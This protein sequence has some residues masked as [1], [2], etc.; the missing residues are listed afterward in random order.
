MRWGWI[1]TGCCSKALGVGR[2]TEAEALGDTVA[3]VD[4]SRITS[5]NI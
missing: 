1:V 4:L 2:V 3:V 5:N